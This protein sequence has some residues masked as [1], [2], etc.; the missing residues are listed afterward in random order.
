MPDASLDSL[1][2]DT[3][4]VTLDRLFDSPRVQVFAK[5][6]FMNPTGSVKDRTA[7]YVMDRWMREGRLRP[8]SRVVESTSGNLGVALALQCALRQV[9]CTLV[10]DPLA[11]EAN[12]ALMRQY[13]AEVICVEGDGSNP[14][15]YLPARLARVHQ[16]L[17]A[18]PDAVWLNQ[19][20]NDLNWMSHY[21]GVGAEISR[22]IGQPIDY[23]VAGL[24]TGGTITGTARRLREDNPHLRVIAVDAVG[25]VIFGHEP[26]PRRIPGLGAGVVPSV[27]D[28]S[29][30]DDVIHVTDEESI[31]GCHALLEAEHL[32]T[33]GSSGAVVAAI[34]RL[35]PDLPVGATVATILPDRGDRYLG[36][37]YRTPS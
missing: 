23:L 12:S 35:L 34:A 15:G 27:L 33:G 18:D 30:I 29:L 2:G 31:A 4:L 5:L 10:I 6:E 7:R 36:L 24:S 1:C 37:I 21:D 3:P 26:R 20:A 13:G 14:G 22:D 17:D 25:S 9:R 16:I 19:Y 32:M 11:R 8:G 28:F